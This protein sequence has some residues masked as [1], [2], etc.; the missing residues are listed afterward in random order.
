[1]TVFF[2]ALWDTKEGKPRYVGQ[3]VNPV[4]RCREHKNSPNKD[5]YAWINEN[6]VE[7]IILDHII[8]PTKAQIKFVESIW[9]RKFTPC[10]NMQLNPGRK[11]Q[12]VAG[13]VRAMNRSF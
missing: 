2:Y 1:M 11:W 9:I 6:S 5:L 12:Y 3:T 7:Y 13:K 4:A 8:D 10:Y